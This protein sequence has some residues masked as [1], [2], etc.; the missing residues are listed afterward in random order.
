[1]KCFEISFKI[2]GNMAFRIIG[3]LVLFKTVKK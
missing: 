2:F 1:M 3:E